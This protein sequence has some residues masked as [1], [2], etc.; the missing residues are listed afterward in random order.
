MIAYALSEAPQSSPPF[1]GRAAP[2]VHR[3]SPPAPV[4]LPC[5]LGLLAFATRDGTGHMCQVKPV[6][7][8]LFFFFFFFAES[9]SV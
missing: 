9:Y 5:G 1:F 6:A 8:F 2:S 3:G 4:S 7:L